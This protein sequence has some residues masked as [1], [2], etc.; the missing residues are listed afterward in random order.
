MNDGLKKILYKAGFVE[1]FNACASCK[2][3][4]NEYIEKLNKCKTEEQFEFVNKIYFLFCMNY[5]L[6]LSLTNEQPF[7]VAEEIYEQLKKNIKI[8]LE[9]EE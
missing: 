8:Y 4:E 9:S 6:M 3:L 5:I 1:F 7:E 2:E